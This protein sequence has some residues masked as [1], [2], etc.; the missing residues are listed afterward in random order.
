MHYEGTLCGMCGGTLRYE[1]SRGCVA[2]GRA[3]AKEQRSGDNKQA[4]LAYLKERRARIGYVHRPQ[5]DAIRAADN[6]NYHRKASIKAAEKAA[7]KAVYE[8]ENADIIAAAAAEKKLAD[9]VRKRAYMRRYRRENP[10]KTAAQTRTK[11]ARRRNAPGKH[12][13]ADV[14]SIGNRQKWR[15]AWC[16][17]PCSADY[18]VDHIIPLAKGGTNWPNNLCIACPTCNMSK[19]DRLPHVFA[20]TMGMLL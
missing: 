4:F 10:V 9:G 18:H 11:K 12:T 1:R 13:G 16:R 6:A 5:T 8:S 7:T 14:T 15:C 3:H 17:K 19:K 20:Q 2:C